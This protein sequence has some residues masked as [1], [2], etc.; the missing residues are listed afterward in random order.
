M[1]VIT[2][3][4]WETARLSKHT[5]NKLVIQRKHSKGALHTRFYGTPHTSHVFI[6]ERNS[7]HGKEAV[8]SHN[9]VEQGAVCVENAYFHNYAA[10]LHSRTQ[11]AKLQQNVT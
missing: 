9:G 6:G 7:Q 2:H 10:C 4:S 11:V 1:Y 8:K 3:K 5:V